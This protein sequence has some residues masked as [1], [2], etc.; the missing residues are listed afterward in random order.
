M[1]RF[2][3]TSVR[4][5]SASFN[6]FITL[7]T[8]A[9]QHD[10]LV[11]EQRIRN[12]RK[13]GDQ[14]SFDHDDRPRL[15]HVED[16]HAPDGA[17]RIGPGELV[18]DVVRADDG[19]DIRLLERRAALIEILQQIVGDIRP[20]FIGALARIIHERFCCNRG[21]AVPTGV[22]A[23]QSVNVL[24][25]VRFRPSWLRLPVSQRVCVFS[26]R[27]AMNNAGLPASDRNPIP[28]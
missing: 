18:H 16:R 21:Y 23:T 10:R 24:F 1:F 7:V 22:L 4:A 12:A 9:E 25:Q 13:A 28:A 17:R 15:V 5:S 2:H 8:I 11:G 3:R 26:R 20:F 27:T 19:H 6:R 14:A